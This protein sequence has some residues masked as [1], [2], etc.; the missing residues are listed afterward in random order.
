[1][2]FAL[3]SDIHANLEA[4]EKACSHASG[5]GIS[6]F[7]VLGDTVGY[8][9]NPNECF[10]WALARGSAVLMG[11]H[12]KALTDIRLR[13][14]FNSAAAAAIACFRASDTPLTV[15]RS[16]NIVRISFRLIC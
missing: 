14:I 3:F 12:E 16:T 2:K 1:M 11:N 4:L 5:L 8:G 10:E 15:L 9:A 6:K 13:T 7:Y